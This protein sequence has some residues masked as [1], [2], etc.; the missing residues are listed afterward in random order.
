MKLKTVILTVV[1]D[2]DDPDGKAVLVNKET[3]EP[4]FFEK[5]EFIV[6]SNQD[7]DKEDGV[8]WKRN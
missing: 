6:P 8:T 3:R 4:T 2:A 5:A 1:Y 7:K